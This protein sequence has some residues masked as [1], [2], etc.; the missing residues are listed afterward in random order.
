[1]EL[2]TERLLLRP[3]RADDHGGY[4]T[5]A[6]G[7]LLR[8]GF[9]QAGL[10]RITATCDPENVGSARILEKIGMRH[11]RHHYLIHGE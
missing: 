1:M 11:L 8:F 4:A 10:H 6:A 2:T 7:A 9:D 3:F 5:E